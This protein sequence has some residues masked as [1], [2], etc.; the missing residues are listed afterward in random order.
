MTGQPAQKAAPALVI[1][2]QLILVASQHGH[3]AELREK[4]MQRVALMRAQRWQGVYL[5]SCNRGKK[6]RQGFTVD[7]F[8]SS[9]GGN[10]VSKK[11]HPPAP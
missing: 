2:W 8:A 7:A 6:A 9:E 10:I 4:A 5:T 3:G 11:V 1:A